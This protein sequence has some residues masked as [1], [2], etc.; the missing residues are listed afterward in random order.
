MANKKISDLT[1]ISALSGVDILE[2]S[3]DLGGSFQTRKV[4]IS[5]L[6]ERFGSGAAGILPS[7]ESIKISA[8]TILSGDI[9]NKLVL[10]GATADAK[11]TF[12]VSLLADFTEVISFENKS[13]FRLQIEVSNISGMTI[14]S[15][16]IDIMNW[17]G[18][19]IITLNGDSST[20]SNTIAG[21]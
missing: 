13:D 10:S 5:Q 15:T 8:Y 12:D 11:F 1:T 21:Y 19:G 7:S 3:E 6:D 16:K 4:S 20:N 2:I 18:D 9:G 14:N 17:K